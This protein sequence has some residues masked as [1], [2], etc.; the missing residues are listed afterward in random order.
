MPSRA[1]SSQR[2]GAASGPRQP[3]VGPVFTRGPLTDILI[4]AILGQHQDVEVI[5]RGAYL[6]VL[7]PGRCRL[8]RA[9]V[10]RRLGRP[11]VLPADLEEVMPAF[12][13]TMS[14]LDDE[15]IWQASPVATGEDLRT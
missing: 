7:V 9:D 4:A 3:A 14:I 1:S 15:V 5:D 2:G 13:G 10:E 8:L 6:R 12:K 11:F